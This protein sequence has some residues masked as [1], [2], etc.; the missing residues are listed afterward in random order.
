MSAAAGSNADWGKPRW[1]TALVFAAAACVA[2][3]WPAWPG[4]MSYDS[5]F[6]YEESVS[7]VQTMTWP[8]LH[9]Y[10]F[11]LS[12]SAG[13]GPWGLFVAQTAVLFAAGAVTASLFFRRGSRVAVTL[14]LFAV[15]FL[16]VPPMLGTVMTQWRDVTT[17]SLA[18]AAVAAWLLAARARSPALL[19]LAAALIGCAV[20][21]RYNAFALFV[22][23]A[24]IMLW[25]PYIHAPA[26]ARL[27]IF[28]AGCLAVSLGLAWAS[29]H[30][31]LPDLKH[32][33]AA[34]NL[35]GIQ[36]FDLIGISACAGRNFLPLA[37]TSGWPLTPAQIRVLYDPRHVQMSFEPH[38][39]VP[40]LQA[41]DAGGEVAEYWR[42]IVPA[43]FD[44]YLTHRLSVFIE[45][46][47]IAKGAVFYPIHGTID[48]NRFHI[49]LAHPA[50]SRRVTNYVI[51]RSA[52]P[53][54]RPALL[55]LLA[56]IVGAV[57][58]V[59]RDRLALPLVALLGG[60]LAYPALLF[61]AAPAADAR[62][63]FPSNVFCA[64]V[65]AAGLVA[66]LSRDRQKA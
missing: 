7:G 47:G 58:V 62:Y 39:G 20:A 51:S 6:A 28:V 52:E 37:A 64:F 46:M 19:A 66:L 1:I 22:L 43:N 32:L 53:W 63:I 14:A 33:P 65:C 10:L 57:L 44:C 3:C 11:W 41:T 2:I 55:Y 24:P 4:Y 54:R 38:P 23:I 48:P 27:R 29:T 12:R 40:A 13:A 35:A 8:P 9:A 50:A 42:K 34:D 49:A 30:W 5:L 15:A 61:V 18:L 36:E 17:A 45:Q 56:M 25:R 26:T 31:R 16:A 60:G 59:R 21:L